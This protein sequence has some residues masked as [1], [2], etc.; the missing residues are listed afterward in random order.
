MLICQQFYPA[1]FLYCHCNYSSSEKG[2]ITFWSCYENSFDL[3]DG[4]PERVLE[5]PG[6][7]FGEAFPKHSRHV[8]P[9]IPLS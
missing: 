4:H 7:Y 6:L 8:A 3:I 1:F 9:A 5:P 2:Q